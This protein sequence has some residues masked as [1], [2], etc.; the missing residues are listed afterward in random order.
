MVLLITEKL[1]IQFQDL[2]EGETPDSHDLI[3]SDAGLLCAVNW[4][5]LIDFPN[6]GLHFHEHLF[7][8]QIRFVQ[9][10]PVG[11]GHLLHCLVLHTFGLH[12]TQMLQDMLR[13]H[14]SDDTIQNHVGLNVVIGE[15]GLS[16]GRRI[17]EA[18]RLDD[19]TIELLPFFC[20]SL[21][22]VLQAPN[23]VSAHRAADTTI[24]HFN[25]LFCTK[26][27]PSGDECIVN[28]DLPKLVFDDGQLLPVHVVQDVVQQRRLATSQETRENV[29]RYL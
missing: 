5:H 10:D 19:D 7:C 26:I 9:E 14:N 16:H 11:K 6:A 29:N 8:D 24:V 4:R 27:L 21:A 2:V 17:S 23:Q 15:E 18:R 28:P 22:N 1:T 3:K 13:I 20:R 12:L 25:D